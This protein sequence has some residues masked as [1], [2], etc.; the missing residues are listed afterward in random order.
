MDAPVEFVGGH[1][2][3][4]AEV[5]KLA[6]APLPPT[7][8][9]VEQ[10]RKGTRPVDYT[11]EGV[12]EAGIYTGELLEAGMTFDGPAIVETKGSTTVIHPGNVVTVDQFGN[13]I[14]EINQEAAR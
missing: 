12:H 4:I 2:V 1:G 8:R 5:G 7:G 6:P 11:T 9:T 10:A 14:I 3:A 13:M